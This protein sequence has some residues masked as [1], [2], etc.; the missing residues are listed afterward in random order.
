[1]VGI[2]LGYGKSAASAPAKDNVPLDALFNS[3]AGE[4]M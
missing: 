3:L 4:G 2:Y 1:M